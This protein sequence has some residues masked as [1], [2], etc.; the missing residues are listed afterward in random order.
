MAF[1]VPFRN[2]AATLG[3]RPWE[4]RAL[5]QVDRNFAEL[6][7]TLV[8]RL[9][10]QHCIVTRSGQGV[11][12][13]TATAIAFNVESSDPFGLHSTVTDNT[14]VY[15]PFDALF[16]VDVEVEYTSPAN[17]TS[18]YLA[19]W[20]INGSPTQY[21]SDASL[22]KIA[23]GY[24]ARGGNG[25]MSEGSYIEALAYQDNGTTENVNA[26]MAVTF[27]RRGDL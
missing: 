22:N 13:G 6:E 15:A 19:G 7:K 14:R 2:T 11:T 1:K 12:T 8:D 4:K 21:W 9:Y 23:T 16:I 20:R 5:E 27:F 3:V 24:A 18:R 26:R 17:T 25:V 10:P